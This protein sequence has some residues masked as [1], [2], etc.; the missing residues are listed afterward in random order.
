MSCCIFSKSHV[1]FFLLLSLRDGLRASASRLVKLLS[2]AGRLRLGLSDQ[3]AEPEPS[4][5][6]PES[7][8]ELCVHP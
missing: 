2:L 1:H 8:L 4:L 5:V 3:Q 6:E 7:S